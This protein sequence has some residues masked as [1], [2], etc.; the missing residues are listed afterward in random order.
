MLFRWLICIVWRMAV[1]KLLQ[2]I[3]VAVFGVMLVGCRSVPALPPD[4]L[5]VPGWN[6]RQG[7]AV[8]KTGGNELAGE[9]I[10][11]MRDGSSALQ[12]I[13]TPLPL[14]SAQTKNDRWTIR[15]IADNRT[16][17][18]RG[19]P[20]HQLIWLHVAPALRGIAIRPPL[21]FKG[22]TNWELMNRKTGEAITGFLSP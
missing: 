15:F 19:M 8:W 14:V 22:G 17:S 7:Q 9:L 21:E 11:A 5:S 20:P 4:D 3:A 2:R 6:M 12:F 18:G 16:I 1:I 10:L 13:K